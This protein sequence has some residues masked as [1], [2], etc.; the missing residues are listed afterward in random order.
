ME[1]SNEIY[2][3]KISIVTPSYNQGQYLEASILSVIRQDYL[4]VEYLII[5]GGSSDNTLEVIKEY[6]SNIHYWVSEPD[7]GVYDAMNKGWMKATGEWV[8]FMGCDDRLYNFNVLS[9][10]VQNMPYS[11]FDVVYGNVVLPN[12]RV[13]GGEFDPKRLVRGP[14]CHQAMFFKNGLK[15]KLPLYNTRYAIRADYDLTVRLYYRH[16]IK[17]KFID[18]NIAYFNDT[19]L[20]SYTYDWEFEKDIASNFFKYFSS[21]LTKREILEGIKPSIFFHLKRGD[22]FKGLLL[23]SQLKLN[24]NNIKDLFYCLK[25]RIGL[26]DG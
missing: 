24:F 13:K 26:A 12:G 6:Q 2:L 11:G 19:G 18:V 10:V 22:F 3:P 8:Y 5:D 4:N 23:F 25:V 9:E 14:I 16:N 20:H 21:S 1:V 7:K 17:F 15:T